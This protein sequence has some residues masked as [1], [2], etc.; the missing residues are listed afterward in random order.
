[1]PTGVAGNS[2]TAFADRY[3]QSSGWRVVRV[4]GSASSGAS[5]G[6]SSVYADDSSGSRDRNFAG[7][8]AI[9]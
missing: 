1:M 9:V 8:L 5:A 2:S 7:R 4:G 3:F 6:P